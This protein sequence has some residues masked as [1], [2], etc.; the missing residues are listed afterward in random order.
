MSI[1]GGVVDFEPSY[2][3]PQVV[4]D[5][6]SYVVVCALHV[7]VVLVV[8]G[9]IGDFLDIVCHSSGLDMIVRCRDFLLSHLVGPSVW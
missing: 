6:A 4:V 5:L 8:G 1:C 2:C 3:G 7:V 9:E